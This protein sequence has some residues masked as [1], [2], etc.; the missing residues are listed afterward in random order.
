MSVGMLD[1][2]DSVVFA[3]YAST[4]EAK[5]GSGSGSGHS[6]FTPNDS[7]L[8]MNAIPKGIFYWRAWGY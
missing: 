5:Y 3:G 8:S 4:S 7:G 2:N 6:G 1:D